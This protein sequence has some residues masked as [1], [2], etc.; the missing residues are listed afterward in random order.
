MS[1]FE[2]PRALAGL[3]DVVDQWP[4]DRPF[5]RLLFRCGECREWRCEL[6]GAIAAHLVDGWYGFAVR[7]HYCQSASV[8]N[9]VTIFHEEFMGLAST[10]GIPRLAL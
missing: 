9:A 7:C 3:E 5:L 8:R 2:R 1:D 6:Q 4:A 10:S